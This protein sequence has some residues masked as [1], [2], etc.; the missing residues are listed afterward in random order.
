M[1]QV[2]K[3]NFANYYTCNIAPLEAVRLQIQDVLGVI[4]TKLL[5][6]AILS[7][8]NL[9]FVYGS[10]WLYRLVRHVLCS[11]QKKEKSIPNA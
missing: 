7:V 8:L 4:P 2:L 9:A 1:A 11:L 6:I 5:Y 3:T 10:Y